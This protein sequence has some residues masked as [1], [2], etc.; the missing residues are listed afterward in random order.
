MNRLKMFKGKKFHFIGVGGISMSALAQM[1]KRDGFYVQGS[2][3]VINCE[4]KK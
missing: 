2:D 3:E 4:V 1:L